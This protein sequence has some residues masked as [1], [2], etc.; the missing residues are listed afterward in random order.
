MRAR[1]LAVALAILAF[2]VAL[3]V[4]PEGL[5]TDFRLALA[6]WLARSS[7]D[8]GGA[9]PRP[10]LPPEDDDGRWR[11]LAGELQLRDAEIAR[12]RRQ[13]ADHG[14]AREEYPTLAFVAARIV[15]PGADACRLVIDRGADDGV[16]AGDGVLQG[17]A[18]VATVTR[19][20]ARAAEIALLSSPASVV[21]ARLGAPPP[22]TEERVVH[23]RDRCVAQ[24]YGGGLVRA[25]FFAPDTEAWTGWTLV[26]SGLDGRLPP[27]LLIGEL[28][29][30]P[31]ETGE[32]GVREAGV[33]WSARAAALEEVL[34]IRRTDA[35]V[36]P[37]A[38]GTP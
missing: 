34:V 25:Q 37:G 6:G 8:G 24:G 14:A 32:T 21:P 19:A 27:D 35:V 15:A 3:L 4:L 13:L 9:D 16:A 23:W 38:G 18:L 1:Q 2:T 31:Q 7:A 33:A 10:L 12:L 30:A 11:R 17:A 26:T 22:D 5:F 28:T 20:G 36:R 29:S